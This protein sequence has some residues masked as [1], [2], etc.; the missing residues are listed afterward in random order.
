MRLLQQ[1]L[2]S[3][4]KKTPFHALVECELFESKASKQDDNKNRFF[5]TKGVV[6]VARNFAWALPKQK[7]TL[8]ETTEL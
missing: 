7:G 2:F 4:L 6:S 3:M 1:N 8:N 5:L